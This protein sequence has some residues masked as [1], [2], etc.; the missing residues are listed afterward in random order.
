[1]SNDVKASLEKALIGLL[2]GIFFLLAIGRPVQSKAQATPGDLCSQYVFD[3]RT[4]GIRYHRGWFDSV[5]HFPLLPD[6][7]KND[8]CH[9]PALF[10]VGA[11]TLWFYDGHR[12]YKLQNSGGAAGLTGAA[13]GLEVQGTNAIEGYAGATPNVY[14]SIFLKTH[15]NSWAFGADSTYF[16]TGN[17]DSTTGAFFGAGPN[18]DFLTGPAFGAGY[19]AAGTRNWEEI[20]PAGA[21]WNTSFTNGDF[22]LAFLGDNIFQVLSGS[23]SNAG[24][25]QEIWALSEPSLAYSVFASQG[26][27]WRTN[28]NGSTD[29]NPTYMNLD[30]GLLMKTKANPT[31]NGGGFFWVDKQS[32]THVS[33]LSVNGDDSL[34]LTG[35]IVA[36]VNSGLGVPFGSSGYTIT[37]QDQAFFISF[38]TG[39]VITPG[40]D[41]NDAVIRISWR[42]SAENNYIVTPVPYNS[43]AGIAMQLIQP[44]IVNVDNQTFELHAALSNWA[45]VGFQ[46]NRQYIFAFKTVDF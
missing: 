45:S 37:G 9:V 44:Y 22:G 5:F 19:K 21:G 24:E 30:S 16:S 2:Y 25:F 8:T 39:S 29:A 33:R 35:N 4:Y 6:T 46:P 18:S 32:T 42:G 20:D 15:Q 11:A 12:N 27:T 38:T 34:T 43:T 26:M 41:S 1:M 28:T 31:S 13:N 23:G 14:R 40:L 17:V 3:P 10:S 7:I 36:V